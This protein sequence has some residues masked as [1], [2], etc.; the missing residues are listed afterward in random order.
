MERSDIKTALRDALSSDVWAGFSFQI[1]RLLE[2]FQEERNGSGQ[3]EETESNLFSILHENL[4][5]REAISEAVLVAELLHTSHIDWYR[6]GLFET[7]SVVRNSGIT[8]Q[9][10][11][12][13]RYI[14]LLDYLAMIAG[15][16]RDESSSIAGRF[17]EFQEWISSL[18]I[19]NGGRSSSNDSPVV[20]IARGINLMS[21]PQHPSLQPGDCIF[22][23]LSIPN[24][25]F[26]KVFKDFGHVAIY[27]GAVVTGNGDPDDWANYEIVEMD[28]KQCVLS[29]IANFV[30]HG[31]FW[32]AYSVDLTVQQRMDVVQ[33]ARSYVGKAKY[34]LVGAS[35]KAPS[36]PCFR[37]DG[38]VE[39]CYEVISSSYAPAIDPPLS[40][41]VGLY[42]DDNWLSLRPSVLRNCFTY[43][44]V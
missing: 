3:F 26:G 10:S 41:R 25:L 29:T 20:S 31:G 2:R 8:D 15:H 19:G 27:T 21:H 7:L 23:D 24:Y 39:H 33:L 43:K 38:L 5:E 12:R 32:G 11:G 35:Y 13:D 1:D 42:V 34:G 28:G 6:R 40:H 4:I 14:E 9:F 36:V 30:G 18:R 44:V 37:C 17:R 16:G 22:R